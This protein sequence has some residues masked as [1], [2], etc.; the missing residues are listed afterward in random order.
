MNVNDVS[1]VAVKLFGS[2]F[3]GVFQQDRLES[4][5]MLIDPNE[6]VNIVFTLTA[7]S[8]YVAFV[9]TKQS[10]FLIDV[11]GGA[12]AVYDPPVDQ[13]I[14]SFEQQFERLPFPVCARASTTYQ[15]V[16]FFS[17]WIVRLKKVEFVLHK[18]AFAINNNHNNERI[19]HDWFLQIK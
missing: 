6:N 4:A 5:R 17:F 7:S 18:F 14:A 3:K 8:G 1:T 19:V 11:Q 12:T 9:F 16:L 15:F 10:A 13:F 2:S